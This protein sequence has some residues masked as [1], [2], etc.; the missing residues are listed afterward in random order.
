MLP[1]PHPP[2]FCGVAGGHCPIFPALFFFP[3]APHCCR[4]LPVF[5]PPFPHHPAP[6]A[7]KVWGAATSTGTPVGLPGWVE[8]GQKPGQLP[9]DPPMWGSHPPALGGLAGSGSSVDP[10]S[11]AGQGPSCSRNLPRSRFLGRAA[12]GPLRHRPFPPAPR[13]GNR[14]G[15]HRPSPPAGGLGTQRQRRARPHLSA[16]RRQETRASRD[17]PSTG[18][19]GTCRAPHRPRL[20]PSAGWR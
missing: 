19:S 18:T 3:S 16:R 4:H 8:W 6:G 12:A 10:S 11:A 17:Q 5:A 13:G 2:R 7:G 1:V 9:Q 15:P 20:H 14:L